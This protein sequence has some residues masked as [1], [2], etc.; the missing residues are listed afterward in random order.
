MADPNVS[1]GFYGPGTGTPP[2]GGGGG[3]VTL[4]SLTLEAGRGTSLNAPAPEILYEE[5]VDFGT[6][7]GNIHILLKAIV[8]VAFGPSTGTFTVYVNATAPGDT[9]GGT[10][11]ATMTT[12]NTVAEK[13]L[14][15]GAD[16]VNPG[17]NCL[18]QIVGEN[19]TPAVDSSYIRGVTLKVLA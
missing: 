12:S 5:D 10:V 9:A 13:A 3:G 11:C 4:A 14:A 2:G 8:Q 17:G 15:V 19:S 7:G 16:F 18:V 1:G 6:P